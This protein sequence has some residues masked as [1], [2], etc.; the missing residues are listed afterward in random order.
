MAEKKKR[1]TKT[2]NCFTVFCGGHPLRS[3]Y[4]EE[5]ANSIAREKK[6]ELITLGNDINNSEFEVVVETT[7]QEVPV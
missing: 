2:V 4:D 1:E 7:S 3:V 5:L 6:R